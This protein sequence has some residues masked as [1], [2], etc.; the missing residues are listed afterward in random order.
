[1]PMRAPNPFVPGGVFQTKQ[2]DLAAVYPSFGQLQIQLVRAPRALTHKLFW[3]LSPPAVVDQ[4]G[5]VVSP[6]GALVLPARPPRTHPVLRPP[7]T[8]QPPPFPP[9]T[10]WLTDPHGVIRTH[11]VLRPPATLAPAPDPRVRTWLT[12]TPLKQRGVGYGLAAPAIVDLPVAPPVS[13]SLTYFKRQ[14]LQPGQ[15]KL[16]AP[17]VVAPAAQPPVETG[18]FITLNRFRGRRLLQQSTLGA[19]TV[20]AVPP[21]V[22][23]PADQVHNFG[24]FR[25]HG[26]GRQDHGKNIW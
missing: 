21:E 22:G 18:L 20:L 19:P 7:A 11:P 16:R 15:Y 26:W 2:L 12:T 9:I 4:G 5:V 13:V 23:P 8:L 6:L 1:M 25:D 17:L 14:I 24:A 10:R 3:R